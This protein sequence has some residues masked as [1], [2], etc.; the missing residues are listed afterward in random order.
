MGSTISPPIPESQRIAQPLQP[1]PQEHRSCP[2]KTIVRPLNK[3]SILRHSVGTVERGVLPTAAPSYGAYSA[4]QSIAHAQANTILRPL[5]R[6]SI[7]KNHSAEQGFDRLLP[8]GPQ[9]WLRF[10]GLVEPKVRLNHLRRHMQLCHSR[11]ANTAATV[12]HILLDAL[13]R[14][15]RGYVGMSFQVSHALTSGGNNRLITNPSIA[16]PSKSLDAVRVH[17]QHNPWRVCAF[18]LASARASLTRPTS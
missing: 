18:A 8:N 4:G 7:V 15:R 16:P 2:T 6:Y 5:N 13:S 17:V 1:S 14:F 9:P 12:Q 3:S 11:I 10:R